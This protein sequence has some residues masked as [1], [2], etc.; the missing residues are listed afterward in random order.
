MKVEKIV[1]E[2]FVFC[3]IKS[4]PW[5]GLGLLYSFQITLNEKNMEIVTLPNPFL[6]LKKKKPLFILLQFKFFS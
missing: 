6:R 1:D 4:F 3:S 5:Y 2:N